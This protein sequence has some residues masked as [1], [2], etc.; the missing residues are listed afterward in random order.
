MKRRAQKQRVKLTEEEDFSSVV[1]IFFDSKG[2]K[3]ATLDQ[4]K[5][6]RSEREEMTVV[7][8]FPG[9]KFVGCSFENSKKAECLAQT[10]IATVVKAGKIYFYYNYIRFFLNADDL[11]VI[12]HG[13]EKK[14][15]R[16]IRQSA[17]EGES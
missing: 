10:V 5:V 15:T 11:C 13:V 14:Q 7:L 16:E 9:K 4:N 8:G 12:R 3:Y 6:I 1:C 2:N 17:R